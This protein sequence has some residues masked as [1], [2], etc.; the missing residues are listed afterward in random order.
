MASP[1]IRRSLDDRGRPYTPVPLAQLALNAPDQP[2][3][4]TARALQSSLRAVVKEQTR[5]WS[6]DRVLIG[7]LLAAAIVVVFV[8]VAAVFS[9]VIPVAIQLLL[10]IATIAL[11]SHIDR[12]VA[13]RRIA[14]SIGA[15]IAAHGFCPSCAYSLN[16]LEPDSQRTLVCPECGSAWLA[17]RLTR[18]HW[19]PPLSRLTPRT[20]WR[21]R[22][23]QLNPPVIADGLGMLCRRANSRL[24]GYDHNPALTPR[25]RRPISRAIRAPSLWLRLA[26]ALLLTA[27]VVW[28][29]FHAPTPDI[30]GSSSPPT[31]DRDVASLVL[32]WFAWSASLLI[33]AASLLMI[34]AGELGITT[35]RLRETLL[36]ESLCPSCAAELPTPDP[37]ASLRPCAHCGSTWRASPPPDRPQPPTTYHHA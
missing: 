3:R 27:A 30:A 25:R 1:F 16:G 10:L 20:P 5:R 21:L 13:A 14:G 4:N 6:L 15:T 24:I 19:N 12:R 36:A 33:V 8:L 28:L 26:I 2:T 18:A 17:A 11:I 22:A 7:L 9:A 35:R 37:G 23:M 32:A 34:L 31:T 29:L